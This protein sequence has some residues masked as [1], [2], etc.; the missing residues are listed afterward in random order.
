VDYIQPGD[1]VKIT[2]GKY[3][4]RTGIITYFNQ[5][6]RYGV[7]SKDII[8]QLNDG[9]DAVRFDN[10]RGLEKVQEDRP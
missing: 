3:A 1:K 8:I 6:N 2:R 7:P 10:D 5:G 4:G 9:E